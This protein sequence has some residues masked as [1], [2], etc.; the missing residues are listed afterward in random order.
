MLYDWQA[1]WATEFDS[2]PSSDLTYH[3]RIDAIYRA[4]WDAGVTT[5]VAHPSA[6]LDRY[7][8]VIVPTL[9]LVDDVAVR[10][11][12]AFVAGGGTVLVTYFSGIVD[13]NDHIRLGGYPGAFRDLLGVR[14]EEF[15][16]LAPGQTVHLD[17]GATADLWTEWLHLTGARAIASYV[18]GPLPG[19][20]AVT[21]HRYG[22]GTAFYVATRLDAAATATVIARCVQRAGIQPVADADP[23]VEVVRRHSSTHSWLFVLN[24][25]DRPARVP[26]TGRELIRDADCSGTIA[27]PA[28][29]VAVVREGG[30]DG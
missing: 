12:E 21:E 7:R 2:H 23:G 16:P 24:H 30:R 10:N 1:W 8:L 17:D 28:G 22:K 3:D 19:I 18:D 11:I 15:F 25:T 13:E 5:D 14:V 6:D 27:V 9:Y 26:A 4:L 20:P 29:E